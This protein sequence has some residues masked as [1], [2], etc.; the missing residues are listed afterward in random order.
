MGSLPFRA[1]QPN[2]DELYIWFRIDL[3]GPHCPSRN[4]PNM[5]CGQGHFVSAI[6]LKKTLQH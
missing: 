3:L 2:C 6:L 5:M 1:N 4:S